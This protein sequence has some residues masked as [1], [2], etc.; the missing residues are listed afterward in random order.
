[1]RGREQENREQ[2]DWGEECE[3]E[4]TGR[5]WRKG[6]NKRTENRESVEKGVRG[7]EQE[8]REQG[9]C[10]EGNVRERTREQRTGGLGRRV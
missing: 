10:G 3:R 5:V 2:E 8:N 7:R 1:M 6:E 9:E 4:R